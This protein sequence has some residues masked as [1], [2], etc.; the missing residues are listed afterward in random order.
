M[1]VCAG[2]AEMKK[3]GRITGTLPT[4]HLFTCSTSLVFIEFKSF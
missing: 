2:G 1:T 4:L 3:G